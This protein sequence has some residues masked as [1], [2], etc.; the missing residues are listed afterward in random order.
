MTALILCT[1]SMKETMLRIAHHYD[2]GL[3][4]PQKSSWRIRTVLG[5][6]LG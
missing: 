2:G 5:R 4:L 6:V 3:S 1:P